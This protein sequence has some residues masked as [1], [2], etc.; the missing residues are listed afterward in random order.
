MNY[1][2]RKKDN[3][4]NGLILLIGLVC[5]WGITMN[6]RSAEAAIEEMDTDEIVSQ[7]IITEE[8]NI[9]IE[10]NE[11]YQSMGQAVE[12]E[13]IRNVVMQVLG[14]SYFPEIE[15]DGKGQFYSVTIIYDETNKDQVLSKAKKEQVAL[16]N[17]CLLMSLFNDIDDVTTRNV[18]GE[19]YDEKVIYRPDIEDYF[20]ISLEAAN[21]KN[22]FTRIANEFLSSEAVDTYW[23]MKHPYDS[24]LGEVVEKFYKCNFPSKW[25][26][27]ETFPYVDETLGADLVEQYGYKFFIQ[28]LNYEHPLMNYYA[29]YRLA[30]Y[31]GN[32]NLDEILLE[33]ASCK[34]KSDNKEVQTVCTWVMNI[35]SSHL[36]EDEVLVFTRYSKSE[37][38]GGRKLYGLVGEKL[39]ELASWQGEQPGGFEVIS[40]SNN[41][42][43][44]IDV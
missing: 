26:E 10:V 28:G 27:E 42:K 15:I 34:N 20:G 31:Y 5:L 25:E 43:S 1:N 32:R 37:L 17:A 9:E 13:E 44:V 23:S 7:T 24:Q 39:V 18:R 29:A 4:K 19:T 8:K 12:V 40:V 33:L 36:E 14:D 35:L 11:L 16:V 30:E 3:I 22:T 6:L 41:K 2:G 38:Q 21:H